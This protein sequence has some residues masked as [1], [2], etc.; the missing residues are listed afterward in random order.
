MDFKEIG[1]FSAI[2]V[3]NRI[4]FDS[5]FNTF[6]AFCL[7]SRNISAKKSIESPFFIKVEFFAT[8]F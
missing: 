6:W 5:F 8:K 2:S 3:K 1:Y 4:N 7:K